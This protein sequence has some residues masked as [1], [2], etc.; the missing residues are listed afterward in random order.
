MFLVGKTVSLSQGRISV[1]IIS[2]R[3]PGTDMLKY[4]YCSHTTHHL[5]NRRQRPNETSNCGF[6]A[7]ANSNC[8]EEA[9]NHTAT[10]CS[11]MCE[12]SHHQYSWDLNLGEQTQ[13]VVGGDKLKECASNRFLSPA[14]CTI[15][16]RD[17]ERR[18][19][20]IEEEDDDSKTI[21]RFFVN[22]P[23]ASDKKETCLGLLSSRSCF[24]PHTPLPRKGQ[25]Q[26]TPRYLL[27]SEHSFKV[28]LAIFRISPQSSLPSRNN[29]KGNYSQG[30]RLFQSFAALC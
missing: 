15:G 23:F 14:D 28:L 29:C 19:E 8:R 6:G 26:S 4:Y 30:P 25:R 22:P 12:M 17:G 10:C 27:L 16:E 24:C 18:D 1:D 20:P 21:R 11:E 13:I 3:A 5:R 2:L 9:K 7:R